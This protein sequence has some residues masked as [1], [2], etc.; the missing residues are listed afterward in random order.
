MD[1]PDREFGAVP[2]L[3]DLP[4]RSRREG[5]ASPWN[6]DPGAPVDRIRRAP[7][8]RRV[9]ARRGELDVLELS[10]LEP[11]REIVPAVRRAIEQRDAVRRIRGRRRDERRSEN[12]LRLLAGHP[13]PKPA[14]ADSLFHE[15]TRLRVGAAAGVGRR[16]V[17]AWQRRDP[18]RSGEK[19]CNRQEHASNPG[20]D[21]AA[22]L[23]RIGARP[24]PV[25][26]AI[27]STGAPRLHSRPS[28][29]T[30]SSGTRLGPYEILAPIGAGGMGEVYRA[31][32]PRLA[33]EV[34]LKV[35]PEEFFE[36]EERRQRFE[37]EA[38]LLAALNHPAIAA[39][40]SFEEIP[41]S[42]SSSSSS[43]SRHLLTMELV[44]GED[45]A[46]RIAS[47]PLPLE[48]S[49]SYARQIAEALEAAH[50]KGIVH[51]DLKPANVKVTPDGQIKLLDFGLAK[52]FE[53]DPAKPGSGAPITESPT[54]T[55]RGTAA[56]MILGTAAYM[57][58]E[59]AR[60]KPVDKRT[61]VWAFGCVLYEMVTGKRA[62]EGETVSDT[63]AAVLKEEPD[64]SALRAPVSSKV[65]E[66][67]R[68]CLQ[69]D[70]KQRPRGM[71]DA[72]SALEEQI[73]ATSAP[74][75]RLPFE[76]NLPSPS[77]TGGRSASTTRER[78]RKNTL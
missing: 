4:E 68:R 73:G 48:E 62:F 45:L 30:I 70:S 11:Q 8:V 20:E 15:E 65:R 59:Q 60:G 38:R 52:I 7:A 63:L 13:Q 67:L 47:G 34:A 28:L 51:R 12:A 1:V 33:R 76:E 71:G 40:Y 41:S 46:Q 14:D 31:R 26:A 2:R 55:A 50:E 27:R 75:A 74:S 57:S 64:W 61:D 6:L 78:G 3:T 19:E 32:D 66:L 58:P 25:L 77:P 9:E 39:I 29:M 53:G 54:L 69:R 10:G 18:E 36:G 16:R 17:R 24:S 56:G 37:R 21:N 5:P 72:R 49:L 42:S 22:I 44:E 23:P 43:S 35:L